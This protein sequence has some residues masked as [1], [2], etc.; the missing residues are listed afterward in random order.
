MRFLSAFIHRP[1]LAVTLM[2]ALFLLG[3]RSLG[4]M[5]ITEFP[6]TK[7][8][9][10]TITT[11]YFGATPKT[12]NAFT[13]APLEK[14]VA[15]V[16][17][18]N[19]MTAVSE[20]G[21]SIITLYMQMG[22]NPNA[23]LSQAQI[24]VNSVLNQLPKG[25]MQPVV[26]EMPGSGAYLMYLTFS[27]KGL[28]QQQITDYLTRVVQPAIQS[29]PGVGVTSILPPGTGPNGNTFAMR[30]WLNPQKMAVLG[31]TPAE[32]RAAL[33]ANDFVSAAGRLRDTNT[34]ISITANTALHSP[35]QFRELVVKT[36]HGVPITL[37]QIATV[38]L[39]AQTY[40]SSVLVNGQPAVNLGV[41][42]APG[43]NALQMATGV[44]KTLLQLDKSM[45][46]GMQAK[47]LYNGAQFV[48]SSIQEVLTDI[49]L[50]LL[51]VIVVVYLF[52]GSWRALVVPALAIPLAL[53][54]AMTLLHA[55]GF[56]LNLL[57]LL[58][59]VLAIG[60]VVDDAI[61]IVENVHRH[62]EH[63]ATPIHAAL[64]SVRELSSPILVMASTIVAVFLP[65][66]LLG[67]LVG[68]LFSEFALTIVA[69]VLMSMV[70]AL[71]LAPMLASRV[72]RGGQPGRF[73]SLVERV[74]DRLRAAYGRGLARSFTHRPA[75]LTGAAL[76]AVGVV[77]LFWLSPQEL[78]PP[79]NQGIVYVS[80]LA[81]A[82]ATLEYMDKYDRYLTKTVFDQVP[83][84]SDSFVVNGVGIGGFLLNN[85]MMSGLVLKPKRDVTTQEVRSRVQKL[86]AQVPGMQLA[87]FG[88]PPLPG[89]A[90]GLPVQFVVSSTSGNYQELN[91]VGEA[92]VK[93]ARAS[94]L[95][96]F[97]AS[98]LEYNDVVLKIQ[99]HKKMLAN[100]GLTLAAV[101]KSLATLLGGNYVNYFSMDGLSYRVVPQVPVALR[102]NPNL[103]QNYQIQ[104]P[105]GAELPL[106][107]FVTLT[108]EVVPTYLP[109][110][111]NLPAVTIEANPAP[112]V[113]LAQALNFLHQQATGLMSSSDQ[114]H[115]AGVSR[116]YEK[117]GSSLA[118]TFA[119]A[120]I[121]VLLLLA[122]QFNGFR[123]SLVVLAGVPLAAFGALLPIALGLS[124]I[125]IYSEV[126]MVMLIGLTA[127]QGILIVQFA[128]QL[129]VERG[130][131]R[132]LAVREAAAL[133]LRPILMT[134]A[135]MIAGAVPLLFATGGN[136]EAR[137][138]MGLVIIAGL[139]VGSLISL[140]VIPAIYSL[141]GAEL[142]PASLEKE[143]NGL[144]TKDANP[145]STALP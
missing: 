96:S 50:A 27:G 2:A 51:I 32:V 58:A 114:I 81:Q 11:H 88:L 140:F 41:M 35:K 71:V 67:G 76:L 25:V 127:K 55:L 23:A 37:G 109:Q 126:G 7:S 80:G 132:A 122:A 108:Q 3:L 70:N 134:V 141:W 74:F 143:G 101:G 39:G 61:I 104:T 89:S 83:Q 63:G 106:S 93:K 56:T 4:M 94:G 103:L 111:Q 85:E 20:N 77:G 6:P 65:M 59:M 36:V 82:T 107:T 54:S 99:I 60:L 145:E 112:G 17:G 84:R 116:Q 14:A 22:V 124:S 78:A 113:S 125:N 121:F 12:V 49:G 1:V 129:Q 10:I 91:H 130:W 40:D 110:F 31:I 62:L 142:K 137:F 87:A 28:N 5:P 15:Q 46:A 45:P 24:K 29:V 53:V 19:Y 115:Y 120:L 66:V 57:T 119:F 75:I 44:K 26:V 95:F 139:S 38:S 90:V 52:L 105:S 72:L 30:I 47:V 43:S 144:L 97:V 98:N 16:P 136:A 102:A 42:Q 117:Q 21:I 69:T 73:A 8:G 92:L 18:I 123:D 64:Q 86:S 131:E 100:F 68:Q 138:S 9:L 133:R 48:R 34:A 13:T 135:A 33:Q 79:A 118:I 128:R